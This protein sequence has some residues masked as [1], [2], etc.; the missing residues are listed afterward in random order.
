MP[1]HVI[2]GAPA[3]DTE[4][5]RVR[6][7]LRASP[8]PAGMLQCPRCAGREVIETKVGMVLTDGKPRGGTKQWL[9]ALCHSRGERV[10]FA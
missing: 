2:N 9:C 1:L 6:A 3:P 4:A 8:K 7:R 10:V 5:E